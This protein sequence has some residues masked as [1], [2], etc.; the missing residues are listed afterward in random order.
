MNDKKPPDLFLF[1]GEDSADLHGALLIEALRKKRP[2]LQISGVGGPKMRQAKMVS[3]LLMEDFHVMGFLDIFFSFWKL[4]RQF[5]YLRKRILQENP[6]I[7]VFIDYPGFNLR[8]ETSLR[9]KGYLGKLVHYISP[10][11][12]AWKKNRIYTLE[13][14]LDLLLTIFPF[15]KECY[16]A[17]KLP[18]IYVG[19]PL[20]KKIAKVQTDLGKIS[21]KKQCKKT[22]IG[23][24]PGS[25][26]KEIGRNLPI[27]LQA[28]ENLYQKQKN[29]SFVVSIA[30]PK[31]DI[32][33][34]H[35]LQKSS[36][37]ISS[38]YFSSG[39]EHYFFMPDMKMAFAKSGTINLELAL[40]EVPTIVTYGI[41]KIDLFLAQKVLKI[42]LPYYCIVNI[43]AQ[44]EVFPELYGPNFTLENLLEQADLFLNDEEKRQKC[45]EECR[46]VK[47][48][49]T[50]LD[51]SENSATILLEMLE[52]TKKSL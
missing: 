31:W 46:E 19:H 23:I 3:W 50:D 12:W 41:T 37:P 24:F 15:E 44:R 34:R 27:Q 48:K 45:K 29:I 21:T 52:K 51:A 11:V 33:I 2:E 30:N 10:S 40:F 5:F 22:L 18:V 4:M 7:C 17:T 49:L 25:R 16:Q 20:I 28:C 8:L 42:C 47:R 36:I 39:E 14:S 35:I 38:F 13:K 26:K 6:P 32:F 9:K 43:I 1:A